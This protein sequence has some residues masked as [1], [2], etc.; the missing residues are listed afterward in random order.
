MAELTDGSFIDRITGSCDSD[1]N[2]SM[3]LQH[4]TKT[5]AARI[6]MTPTLILEAAGI[7]LRTAHQSIGRHLV[8]IFVA[9]ILGLEVCHIGHVQGYTNPG[10]R[11][12]RKA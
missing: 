2:A 8:V 11:L 3:S 12:F 7:H 5:N 1:G 9:N 4:Y 10:H 6:L